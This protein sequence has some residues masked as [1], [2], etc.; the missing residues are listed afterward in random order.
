LSDELLPTPRATAMALALHTKFMQC[1]L[2]KKEV[3]FEDNTP[4]FVDGRI[5]CCSDHE[6]KWLEMYSKWIE[7]A[8]NGNNYA[9]RD[10]P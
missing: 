10:M 7:T 9:K 3:V 6:K 4:R 2:C 1:E 8:Y 5:F